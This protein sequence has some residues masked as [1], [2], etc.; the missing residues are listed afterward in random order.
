MTTRKK[1]KEAFEDDNRNSNYSE[2]TDSNEY[3]YSL[4]SSDEDSYESGGD[5]LN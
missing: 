4:V 1:S 5:E 3:F 2:D